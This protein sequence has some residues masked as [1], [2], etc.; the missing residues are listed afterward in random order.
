MRPIPKR[1]LIHSA[2]LST[3]ESCDVWQKVS[4]SQPAALSHVRLEPCSKIVLDTN[5]T[6]RQQTATLFFD[7]VNSLPKSVVFEEG[8]QVQALGRTYTVLTVE[9]LYDDHKLHHWEV[10]LG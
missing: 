2:Q 1:L 10:G 5:N 6:E 4:Y 8:Q 7:V 9:P 3:P